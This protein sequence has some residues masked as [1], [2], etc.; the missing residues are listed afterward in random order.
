MKLV[1]GGNGFLGAHVVRAL[2]A[3]GEPVRVFSRT[4][5]DMRSLSGLDVDHVSGSLFDHDAVAA[6]M[7]G[8]DVVYHCAVDT[9]A[10]LTDPTP[11]YR[12]NVDALGAVLDVAAR[13]DLDAFVFTSTMATIG[14][15]PDRVVDER[16]SFNWRDTATD[17]VL[18]RVAAEDLALRYAREER[19]P[20]RAMCVSNTYGARDWQP[21]PHG[22]F[23]AAAALGRMPFG[24]RGMRAEAVAVDDAAA[25][26]L[27]AARRGR[28]G[29]RYIVSERYLDLG[30]VITTAATAVGAAPPRL[31]LGKPALYAAG[32]VGSLRTRLTGRPQRL[33]IETVRLMHHMSQMSHAKAESE[34]DWHPRPV[35]DAIAEG[36]RFWRDRR[37]PRAT[38]TQASSE[39][40]SSN[41]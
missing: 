14:R 39:A 19:V 33:R 41:E 26:L 11:L 12:T 2:V 8:A 32:A 37:R 13:A 31:V 16:D 20:V 29:E 27:A 25:A 40:S 36:A 9:R 10:W 21:T 23:V 24:I 18:S 28:T 34:L 4:T 5:S 35:T 22:S 3:D 38:T 7:R 6:A 30:E 17:Y 1:I 15:H